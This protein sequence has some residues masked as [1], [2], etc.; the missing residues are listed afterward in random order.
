MLSQNS[1]LPKINKFLDMLKEKHVKWTKNKKQTI[2]KFYIYPSIIVS[3]CMRER[4][5]NN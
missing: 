5:N 3:M 4:E 2:L 1:E